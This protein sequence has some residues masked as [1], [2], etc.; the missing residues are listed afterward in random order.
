MSQFYMQRILRG[1]MYQRSNREYYF[2]PNLTSGQISDTV[3]GR[4]WG[5]VN[6]HLQLA[7]SLD[8]MASVFS[9][10]SHAPHFLV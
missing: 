7:F 3:Y 9:K 10:S 6:P 2:D 4:L 5:R 1:F 8:F